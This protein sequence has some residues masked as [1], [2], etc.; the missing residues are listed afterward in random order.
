MQDVQHHSWG[1]WFLDERVTQ[2]GGEVSAGRDLT[3]SAGRDLS[4]TASDLSAG[5][6][7]ALRAEH[8]LTVASAADESHALWRTKRVTDQKDRVTQRAATL[9]AE[10]DLDI[11][12]GGD[13]AVIASRVTAGEQ[14][15]LVAGGELALLAAQDS[16]YALHQKKKKGSFGRN[17]FK[18]DETTDVTHV[19]SDIQAGGDLT[20]LSGGDQTYQ[21]ARLES[22]ADLTVS[23]AG[24]IAFEGVKD[25]EQESREKSKSSFAWQSAKG[26]G[27]TDETLVQ[28][29]L[30]AQGET[31]IAAVDGLRIDLNQLDRQTV[32]QS[33]DA[34]VQADPNLAWLKQAEQRGDVDW[35]H[36]KE[37]HDSFK[38]SHSGLG[39]GAAIVVAIAVA[40]FTGPW[41]SNAL[42]GAAGAP[43]AGGAWSA[44]TA[45]QAAGW[46]NVGATAIGTSAASGAAIS[47]LNNRGDLGA[48][49]KD[50]TASDALKGYAV[51]GITAG[52]TTGLYDGWTGTETAPSTASNAVGANTPLSNTGTCYEKY[53]STNA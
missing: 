48:V 38:Y 49:L 7:L 20:L 10:S 15:Y 46:A 2:L 27:K 41:M 21:A 52:L 34:M 28:S 47:T 5:R 35:R 12:A 44:A 24:Q 33:I 51:T 18:R 50:V 29:Q 11:S 6:H 36:V 8:D 9:S 39:G 26:K 43:A 4:V 23:S 32:S 16:D 22:G 13:L 25:L 3:I 53:L 17:S 1:N 19:G 37:I 45:T 30:I 42:A 14:A 31:V 40:Y